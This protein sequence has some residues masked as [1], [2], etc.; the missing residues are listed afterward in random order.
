MDIAADKTKS[1]KSNVHA[2]R[3]ALRRALKGVA[4]RVLHPSDS[5]II[6]SF[7]MFSPA[8]T[9]SA[10]DLA[11]AAVQAA[12]QVFPL[13]L[14]IAS[15]NGKATGTISDHMFVTT[16]AKSLLQPSLKNCTII[17]AAIRLGL[18]TITFSMAHYYLSQRP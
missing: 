17:M 15:L 14:K 6:G 13:L 10:R 1:E 5:R 18:M 8:S 9:G 11:A 16:P 3:T 7:P 12:Q 4:R 2:D